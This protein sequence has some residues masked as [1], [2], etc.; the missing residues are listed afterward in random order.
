LRASE[1]AFHGGH[2]AAYAAVRSLF[3]VR[4]L[5]RLWPDVRSLLDPDDAMLDDGYLPSGTAPVAALELCN[6]LPFQLLHDTDAMSM[7]HAL[8]VRVPLLDEQVVD[9]VLGRQRSGRTPFDKAALVEA[10][11]PDLRALVHRPKRTFTLPF[12]RWIRGTLRERVRASV[13]GL[14]DAGLGLDPGALIDVWRRFEDGHLGWRP[15]WALGILGEWLA[16][17]QRSEVAA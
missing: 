2:R 9:V 17:A 14:A 13:L 3:S 5:E 16:A 6:Y 4:D 8:E 10:V 1:G 11:D 7:A 15:I 12:E